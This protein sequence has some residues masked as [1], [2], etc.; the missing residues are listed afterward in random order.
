MPTLAQ[1]STGRDASP[2]CQTDAARATGNDDDLFPAVNG[3]YA[4][5]FPKDP[6]ARMFVTAGSSLDNILKL[7]RDLSQDRT[8]SIHSRI[9]ADG[10]GGHGLDLKA[11]R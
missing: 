1:L 10:R 4:K 6:P 3:V 7:R 9:R 2:D 8:Q 5:F 11:H